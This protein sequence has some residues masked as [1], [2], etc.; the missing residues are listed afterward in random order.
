MKRHLALAAL[1]AVSCLPAVAVPAFGQEGV[2]MMTAPLAEY[3][4]GGFTYSPPSGEGWRQLP[5]EGADAV[6]FVFAERVGEGSINM[7]MELLVQSF[8]ITDAATV[9]DVASL[10]EKS[11]S[12]QVAYHKDQALKASQVAEVPG[13][14]GIVAYTL[15]L[16]VD[17]MEVSQRFFVALAPDKSQYWVGRVAS[18][19]KNFASTPFYAEFYGSLASLKFSGGGY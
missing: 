10:A 7:R 16:K 2:L 14:G 9:N 12:Q 8:P 19:E 3:S 1:V 6:R 15:S 4:L 11:R 13:T 18:Q 5:M 17:D